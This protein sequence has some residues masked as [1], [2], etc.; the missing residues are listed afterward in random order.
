[1]LDENQKRHIIEVLTTRFKKFNKPFICPMCG[2]G[3]FSLTDGY[4]Q[5]VLQED[6]TKLNLSGQ[7][8]P[9]ISII[10]GNCG[11]MSQ[12]ALGTLGLLPKKEQAKK[13]EEEIKGGAK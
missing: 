12:H 9:N 11:F 8:V 5:P 2:N 3:N 1:M 7:T 10:C 13:E 6:L 4:F